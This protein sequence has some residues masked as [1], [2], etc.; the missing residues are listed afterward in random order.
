[1]WARRMHECRHGPTKVEPYPLCDYMAFVLANLPQLV[2][3]ERHHS[4]LHTRGLSVSLGGGGGGGGRLRQ[5]GAPWGGAG[6]RPRG[7]LQL[8]R[9]YVLEQSTVKLSRLYTR[10]GSAFYQGRE[11]KPSDLHSF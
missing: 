1:M 4:A 5:A 8:K 11:L 9:V 3:C 7:G 10:N 2:D 6:L